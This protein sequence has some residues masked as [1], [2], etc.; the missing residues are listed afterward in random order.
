MSRAFRA[1]QLPSTRMAHLRLCVGNCPKWIYLHCGGVF[2]GVV[3]ED[4]NSRNRF[5]HNW[6]CAGSQG[7]LEPSTSS[8]SSSLACM[9]VRC[10]RRHGAGADCVCSCAA[11][12]RGQ[13]HYVRLC[14]H[15]VVWL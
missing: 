6:M 2:I 7:A 8:T 5:P 4:G 3:S 14:I 1:K 9:G 10:P 12:E 11:F 15:V 13:A